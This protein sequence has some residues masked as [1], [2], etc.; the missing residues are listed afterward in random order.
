MT[1][2]AVHFVIVLD[3][4]NRGTLWSNF[5]SK[6]VKFGNEVIVNMFIKFR[7]RFSSPPGNRLRV[8]LDEVYWTV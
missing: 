5:V 1:K 3:Q 2:T 7:T 6:M 4:I 8:R